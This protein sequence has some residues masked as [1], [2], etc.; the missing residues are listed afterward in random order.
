MIENDWAL[1]QSQLPYTEQSSLR[2]FLIAIKFCATTATWQRGSSGIVHIKKKRLDKSGF[3]RYY[4][5]GRQ[6]LGPRQYR[7]WWKAGKPAPKRFFAAG[8]RE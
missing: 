4:Q 6:F 1:K 8:R 3:I 2:D 7:G 5:D